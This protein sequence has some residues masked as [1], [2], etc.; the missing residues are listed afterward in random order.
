MEGFNQHTKLCWLNRNS[1]I[2][3]IQVLI[4]NYNIYS[5]S[6]DNDIKQDDSDSEENQLISTKIRKR[7]LKKKNIKKTIIQ[8]IDYNPI[9]LQM[10]ICVTILHIL[11]FTSMYKEERIKLNW[12]ALHKWYYQKQTEIKVLFDDSLYVPEIYD[13]KVKNSM[14]TS[15]NTK[16]NL[17]FGIK[18]S[19]KD[20]RNGIYT[21]EKCFIDVFE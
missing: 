4:K 19:R 2:L 17:I 8:S 16:L 18:L 9:F 20:K 6:S 10:N 21:V 7:I 3:T 11:G 15:I 1:I 13:D 5:D 14:S 12:E